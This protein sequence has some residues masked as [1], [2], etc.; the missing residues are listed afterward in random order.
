MESRPQTSRGDDDRPAIDAN[1][2]P[3]TSLTDHLV[4]QIGLLVEM[5]ELRAR[6]RHADRPGT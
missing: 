2:T 1:L 3:A 5:T 4:W 6:D